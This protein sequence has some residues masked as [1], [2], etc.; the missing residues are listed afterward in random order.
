MMKHIHRHTILATVCL[1]AVLSSCSRDFEQEKRFPE[2]P[3]AVSGQTDIEDCM[4]QNRVNVLVSAELASELEASSDSEGRVDVPNVKSLSGTGVNS[5]RRVFPPAGKFESRTREEGLHLWYAV[6]CDSRALT[7][8]VAHELQAIAGIEKLEYVPVIVPDEAEF[9]TLGEASRGGSKDILPFDDPL[10]PHQWDMYN[11]GAEDP[12]I[13]GCD[14]NVLPVWRNLKSCNCDIIVAV[15][16]GGIDFAHEDLAPNM[17]HNPERTGDEVYGKNFVDGSYTI[18]PMEHGTHVAGTIA[19]VGNNGIGISGI[20]GGDSRRGIPGVKLMSCQIFSSNPNL[21]ADFENAIKWGADH[22]SVISQNSW[23]YSGDISL[24]STIRAAIDYFRKYAGLDENGKQTGPMAGGLVVFSTGNEHAHY[25]DGSDNPVYYVGALAPDYSRAYYSNYGEVTDIC[26]PGGDRNKGVTIL[27]TLPDNSY[28]WMQGTSMACP[29]VSGTAALVLSQKA[30]E[31]F[32]A[33]ELERILTE[34]ATDI[35]PYDPLHLM[36]HGLV[37]AAAALSPRG[38]AAPGS[39]EGLTVG[40]SSNKAAFSVTVPEDPDGGKAERIAIYYSE[41]P[42]LEAAGNRFAIFDTDAAKD[43]ELLHGI[44]NGL[45]FDREYYF[46]AAA[47]DSGGNESALSGQ[48][49]AMTSS[50][51][52]PVLKAVSALSATIRSHEVHRFEFEV[53]DQDGHFCRL[54]V[55]EDIYGLAVDETDLSRPALLVF[56]REMVSGDFSFPVYCKDPYGGCDSAGVSFTI[57][58]NNAP[59]VSG[60]IGN[61]VLNMNR[62]DLV[63]DLATCFADP[64]GEDLSFSA[65]DS[66]EGV[67]KPFVS[68]SLLTLTPMECGYG[69]VEVSCRDARGL[70][71]SQTFEVLVRSGSGEFDV[72]PNPVRDYLYVRTEYTVQASLKI[73]SQ[74]GAMVTGSDIEISPFNAARIDMQKLPSGL[75]TVSLTYNGKSFSKTVVKI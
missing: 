61:V 14:V 42:I 64:D 12:C 15:V 67:T 52:N 17:W 18:V 62:E 19:A 1:A 3:D 35:T 38:G 60:K 65:S 47:R 46:A 27:S 30:G 55:P 70:S 9:F 51:H 29:H 49:R 72:Y 7:K 43:G 73:F 6:E 48:V 45:E 34:S 50:N 57:L 75:Y 63:I 16:D 41:S 56:A 11:D 36:G 39:P 71:A 21:D 68:G 59:Q 66:G 32:T 8:S 23:S 44:I 26:A 28:G 13:A 74:A 2:G 10:L 54:E 5:M 22:G 20:A 40:C 31:G 53:S 24:P 25:Y 58:E 37:N 33:E 4:L 69:K